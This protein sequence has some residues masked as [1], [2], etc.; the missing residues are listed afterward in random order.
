MKKLLSISLIIIMIMMTFVACNNS[1]DEETSSSTTQTTEQ[2]TVGTQDSDEKP[3]NEKEDDK[4][5]D[6]E[7]N[8]T[9]EEE[10]I[11][12]NEPEWTI[13]SLP[14]SSA[15]LELELNE[16]GKG[17]TV[18]GIGTCT[19][20]EI[21]IG[22]YNNLPITQIR[23]HAF[24]NCDKIIGIT[25]GGGVEKIESAFKNCKSI[26]KLNI[27]HIA[28]WCN[29]DFPNGIEF[30]H[31]LSS[32]NL[33]G[34]LYYNGTLVDELIIP[35]GVTKINAYTF[36]GC[37]N[38][39][40]VTWPSSVTSIGDCAFGGTGLTSITI[41]DSVTSIGDFAFS[42]CTKLSNVTISNNITSLSRLVF[43]RCTALD[44]V[45]I[46][47]SVTSIESGAFS[48]C[49]SLKSITIPNSVTSI[50]Y[51]AFLGCTELTAVKLGN[52]VTSI[53]YMAFSGCTGLTTINFQGTKAEW[54]AI[55]KGTDWNS[56]T[57]S[58][59]VKCTDGDIIKSEDN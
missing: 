58:Y 32:E 20:T 25:I 13:E 51:S 54:K 22:K 49:T 2:N 47:N 27:T 55:T 10:E 53:G 41:P 35:N 1:T 36:G 56:N 11:G 23:R 31:P 44:N 59:T 7:E 40:K 3:N 33:T 8:N 50:G 34:K 19:D 29:V 30:S 37:T 46:P 5:S 4:N 38:I 24:E 57:D 18:V 12:F 17:Y 15:G 14:E 48:E 52:G 45:I 6:E 26:T 43:A 42:T 9:N 21:V 28:S 39:K 16:D